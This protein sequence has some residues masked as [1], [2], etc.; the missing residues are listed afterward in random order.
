MRG[1]SCEK[2]GAPKVY[3][4]DLC[5]AHGGR[6]IPHD[7]MKERAREIALKVFE[8]QAKATHCMANPIEPI[9]IALL[10]F[11]G[12]VHKECVE[13]V[14]PQVKEI[15]RLV[16]EAVIRECAEIV[17]EKTFLYFD[18]E[19]AKNMDLTLAIREYQRKEI[20]ERILSLLN[21]PKIGDGEK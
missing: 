19:Q 21:E 4:S 11:A 5:D 8:C 12:E 16:R 2:C 10:Q 14:D 3:G 18:Q 15:K 9:E 20:K 17:S 1:N 13:L 6:T 7:Q